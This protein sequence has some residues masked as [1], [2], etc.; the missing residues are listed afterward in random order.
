MYGDVTCSVHTVNNY[1][2]SIVNDMSI[3]VTEDYMLDWDTYQICYPLEI[4]LL[5]SGK[6]CA[7]VLILNECSFVYA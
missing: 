2:C 1:V 5:F 4:K 7:R 3:F 6:I